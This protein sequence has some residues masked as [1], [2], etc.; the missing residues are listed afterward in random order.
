MSGKEPTSP[1]E[2]STADRLRYLDLLRVVAISAVVIGHWLLVSVTYSHGRLSGQDALDC[3]NWGGWV[4]LGFQVMPVFFLVG[5]YV[6]ARSWT[7]H[8]AAGQGWAAWVHGRAMR[9]LWPTTVYVVPMTL[10]FGLGVASGWNA[11]ELSQAGW[12]TALHLWFLPAYLVVIAVT[13]LMLALHERWGLAVP[14]VMA[15]AACAIDLAAVGWHVRF[16]GFLNYLLV[17]GSMHQWGFSWRDGRLTSPPGRPYVLSGIG[18]VAL[19]ALIGPGPFPIDM[20][21]ANHERVVNTGPPSAALLAFAAVQAGVVIALQGPASRLLDDP[22][23]WR[24]VQRLTPAVMWV[25]LWHMVP[26]VVVALAV[27]RTSPVP[28]P[29]VGSW[30]WW[31]LRPVWLLV[32]GVLVTVLVLG[33]MRLERPLRRLPA[34]IDSPTAWSGPLVAAGLL[35]A[36]IGL[37]RLAI[38]GFAPGGHVATAALAT[39]A[40]GIALL[41]IAA[42]GGHDSTRPR[43][44]RR[45]SETNSVKNPTSTG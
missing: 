27:Y 16:V 41:A 28:Q 33:L 20:I 10:A 19:V 35:A 7:S 17:W 22:S 3:I 15:L 1:S 40:L 38:R 12:L 6:N 32:L 18:L 45:P 36:G 8:R 43:K 44:L 31:A 14:V 42:R 25:Y 13:P 37:A 39:Y 26:V 23:W 4:T 9:L 30:Q 21:G 24:P 2:P 29:A 34:G 11:K 5:G